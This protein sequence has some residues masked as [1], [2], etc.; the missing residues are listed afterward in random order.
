M[1]PEG[2]ETLNNVW[3]DAFK[4]ELL[5]EMTIRPDSSASMFPE[6]TLVIKERTLRTTEDPGTADAE[7]E[8]MMFL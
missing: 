1:Q 5:P 6:T 7:Y 8:L 3:K 2:L 4:P